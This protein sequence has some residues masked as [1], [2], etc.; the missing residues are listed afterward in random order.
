MVESILSIIGSVL[1]IIALIAEAYMAM[2]KS[3]ERKAAERDEEILQ[4][5]R[6]LADGNAPAVEQRLDKLLRNIDENHCRHA[7]IKDRQD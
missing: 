4:G 3:P 1:A 6:D 2:A 5:R 7:G